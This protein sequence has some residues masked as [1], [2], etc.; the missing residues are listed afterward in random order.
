M[1]LHGSPIIDKASNS[2]GDMSGFFTCVLIE[3]LVP[4]HLLRVETSTHPYTEITAL[5]PNPQ[6]CAGDYMEHLHYDSSHL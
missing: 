2:S 6:D 3:Q 1:D 5:T 4:R